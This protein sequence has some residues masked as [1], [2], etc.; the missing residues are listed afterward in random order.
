[1]IAIYPIKWTYKLPT[2]PDTTRDASGVQQTAI[3][4]VDRNFCEIF[5]R[6]HVEFI[7][8]LKNTGK[9]SAGDDDS[10]EGDHSKKQR[11]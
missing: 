4:V 5:P 11:S 1:M 6:D 9:R 7:D 2:L 10:S 8:R 3:N